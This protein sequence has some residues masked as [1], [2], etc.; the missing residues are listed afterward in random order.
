[1]YIS[2]LALKQDNKD[3]TSR[4]NQLEISSKFRIKTCELLEKL[5]DCRVFLF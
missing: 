3:K 1:M 2:A 5:L 4:N